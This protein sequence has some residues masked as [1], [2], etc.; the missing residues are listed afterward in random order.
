MNHL[1]TPV[2]PVRRVITYHMAAVCHRQ[3]DRDGNPN[4]STEDR[5]ERTVEN[6]SP[7]KH[8]WKVKTVGKWDAALFER[9]FF[10]VEFFER[11]SMMCKA[12]VSFFTC[13]SGDKWLLRWTE[14]ELGRPVGHY[15]ST[16][17]PTLDGTRSGSDSHAIKYPP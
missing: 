3:T 7:K 8:S 6:S 4:H 16:R 14:S 5:V 13:M 10:L 12:A 15:E 9:C 11:W 17:I 2:S 1:V